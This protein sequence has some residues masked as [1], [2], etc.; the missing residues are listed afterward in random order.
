MRV[1][2]NMTDTPN[3]FPNSF[4]GPAAAEP[5]HSAWHTHAASGD[6]KRHATGDDDNFSQVYM[7]CMCVLY[8]QCVLHARPL[9]CA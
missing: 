7:R 2:G 9:L 5:S 8:A 3:Y 4:S 1:D 6:V